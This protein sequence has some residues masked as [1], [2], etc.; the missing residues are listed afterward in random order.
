MAIAILFMI[1]FM[2]KL[3]SIK[4]IIYLLLL[5]PELPDDL[6]LDLDDLVL[7]PDDLLLEPEDLT[8]EPDDLFGEE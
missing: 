1:E 3:F 4:T 5:D 6:L 8:L 2:L 7:E